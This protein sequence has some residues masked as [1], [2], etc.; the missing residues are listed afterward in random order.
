MLKGKMISLKSI[1]PED[2]E[3]LRIWRNLPEYRKHF[4]EY[5]EINSAMQLKWY[6]SRVV[7]DNNTLMFSIRDNET[8]ELWGC[9]GLCYINW[10]GRHADLSLYIG[11]DECYI[12]EQGLAEEAC[13]LLFDYAFNEL[14]LNKVWTELYEFDNKKIDLYSKLGMTID[15]RWRKQYFYNGRWWDSLLLEILA[16]EWT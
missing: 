14:G 5:K 10:V 6:E 1:E 3:Q 16:E 2:L 13:A 11:K 15:G 4:R 12:D 8:D 9:C 7:N